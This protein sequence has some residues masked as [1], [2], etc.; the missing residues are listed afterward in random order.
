MQIRSQKKAVSMKGGFMKRIRKGTGITGIRLT[1]AFAVS[2]SLLLAGLTLVTAADA[3]A[4]KAGSPECRVWHLK[5]RLNLT[6]EQ[7]K[8]IEPIVREEM[9]KRSELKQDMIA[10]RGTTRQK[11]AGVLTDEQKREFE[12]LREQRKGK[13][14]RMNRPGWRGCPKE[15]PRFSPPPAAD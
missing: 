2:V 4:G 13:K 12:T 14:S 11:I 7:V 5:E 6:D 9:K 1:V 3:F 8:A 10:L 15:C